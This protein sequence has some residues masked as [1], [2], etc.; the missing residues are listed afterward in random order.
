MQILKCR[1]KASIL[2]IFE[3]EAKFQ[4]VHRRGRNVCTIF[5]LR[6][7]GN[8]ARWTQARSHI[9]VRIKTI[10]WSTTQLKFSVKIC[11]IIPADSE[12][13]WL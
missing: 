11:V 2:T 9:Q 1:W 7:K 6:I 8:T 13:Y 12:F 5:R 3:L 4:I 10:R